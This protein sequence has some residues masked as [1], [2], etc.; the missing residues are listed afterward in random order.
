MAAS[1]IGED[2]E[3]EEQGAIRKVNMSGLLTKCE[4]KMAG[5]WPSS[6]FACLWTETKSRSINSQKKNE[7]NIQP[8]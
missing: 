5:Y 8:S 7:A 2:R 4:V 3:E 1:M 6:F